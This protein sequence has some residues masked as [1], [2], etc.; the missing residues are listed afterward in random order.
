[1]RGYLKFKN[2]QLEFLAVQGFRVLEKIPILIS[3]AK[4]LLSTLSL[5][6]AIRSPP[7][8]GYLHLC[9]LLSFLRSFAVAKSESIWGRLQ[10]KC[11]A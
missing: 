4:H 2:F 10:K 8:T 11:G 9:A 1:M 3:S 7:G 6:P 5:S